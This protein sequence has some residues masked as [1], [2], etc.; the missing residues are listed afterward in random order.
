MP[1]PVPV[2]PPTPTTEI[3]NCDVPPVP[4][5]VAMA[6]LEAAYDRVAKTRSE[7]RAVESLQRESQFSQI[8]PD[9]V[10]LT[11][12]M[13]GESFMLPVEVLAYPDIDALFDDLIFITRQ[14]LCD[15][16]RCLLAATCDA[17]A[18]LSV[19]LLNGS[20]EAL[21]AAIEAERDEDREEASVE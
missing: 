10:T 11:I 15:A 16:L 3:T 1:M 8:T 19:G 13:R 18:V 4:I 6:S 12:T 9:D 14:S 21:A 20:Q 17:S 2:P 7:L 5:D